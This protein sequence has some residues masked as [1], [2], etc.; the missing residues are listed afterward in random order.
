MIQRDDLPDTPDWTP[1]V[2]EALDFS[3]PILKPA[4]QLC[5]QRLDGRGDQ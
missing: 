5:R 4:C 2:R 3:V 1:E